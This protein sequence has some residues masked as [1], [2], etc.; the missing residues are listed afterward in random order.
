MK[1]TYVV[2]PPEEMPRPALSEY[3]QNGNHFPGG[4][5]DL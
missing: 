2:Y 4:L 5:P 1:K 3:S